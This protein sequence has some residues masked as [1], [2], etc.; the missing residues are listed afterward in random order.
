MARR[1]HDVLRH[2]GA[3]R[4]DRGL[5]TGVRLDALR[6]GQPDFESLR[7]FYLSVGF[8]PPPPQIA[9]A[10]AAIIPLDLAEPAAPRAS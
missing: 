9:A 7:A 4:L 1:R 5:D 8:M 3:L 2:R 6:P 10:A